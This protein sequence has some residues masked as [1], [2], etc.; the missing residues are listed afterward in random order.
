MKKHPFEAWG[1]LVASK[2]SRWITLVF[3]VLLVVVLS[4]TMPQINLIFY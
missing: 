1:Q 4:F 2:K 3:W